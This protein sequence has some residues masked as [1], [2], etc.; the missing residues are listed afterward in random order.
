MQ[1]PP[2]TGFI[3]AVTEAIHDVTESIH[4]VDEAGNGICARSRRKCYW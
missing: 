3:V 1:F 2:V 4:I